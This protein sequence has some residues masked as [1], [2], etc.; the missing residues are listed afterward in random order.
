MASQRFLAASWNYDW[1]NISLYTEEIYDP[2]LSFHAQASISSAIKPLHIFTGILAEVFFG[3]NGN[4]G[5][6]PTDDGIWDPAPEEHHHRG[7]ADTAS[8][9][10]LHQDEEQ[11]TSTAPAMNPGTSLQKPTRGIQHPSRDRSRRSRRWLQ[12]PL[13]L[14]AYPARAC[15]PISQSL[16]GGEDRLAEPRLGGGSR[17]QSHRRPPEMGSS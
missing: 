10:P 5:F 15:R 8:P 2:Y 6:T 14:Y 3:K 1:R 11:C 9:L 7:E 13:L 17:E 16:S 4:R 12:D